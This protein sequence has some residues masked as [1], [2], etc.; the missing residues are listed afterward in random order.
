MDSRFEK[1]CEL[2]S[3]QESSKGAERNGERFVGS[4]NEIKQYALS[5]ALSY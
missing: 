2:F 4:V 5:S 3:L 1:A